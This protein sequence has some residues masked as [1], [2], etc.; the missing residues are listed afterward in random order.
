MI[1]AAPISLEPALAGGAIAL[2]VIGAGA[3][4]V[5]G[6]AIKRLAGLMIAGFGAVLALGVLGAPNGALV[7]GV[8]ILFAQ[9]VVGVAIVVR[10]QESY[11]AIEADEID[12]ADREH[13]ARADTP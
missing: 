1:A 12:G 8:A 3:A 2:V 7:A 9:A 13:D 6:N 4:L 10:L 11:G 5:L